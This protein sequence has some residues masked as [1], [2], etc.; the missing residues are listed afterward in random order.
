MAKTANGSLLEDKNAIEEINRHRWI[1]S[2]KAGKDIGF[3]EASS[4]WLNRFSDAWIK[5]TTTKNGKN[6]SN[7]MAKRV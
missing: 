7:R 3:D 1:E 2:E 4:D 6:G 5:G